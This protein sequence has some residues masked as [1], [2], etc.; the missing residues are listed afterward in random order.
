MSLS[1]GTS[2]GPRPLRSLRRCFATGTPSVGRS[3]VTQHRAGAEH[4]TL[5]GG[6]L[7]T[8]QGQQPGVQAQ[9]SP[10]KAQ[11]AAPVA[12]DHPSPLPTSSPISSSSCSQL[13]SPSLLRSRFTL[14]LP[15]LPQIQLLHPCLPPMLLLLLLLCCVD[16]GEAGAT[17]G[18]V[19]RPAPAVWGTAG[20]AAG[21]PVCMGR[22]QARTSYIGL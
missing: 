8:G 21:G 10:L 15:H 3:H 20:S 1:W 16:A 12:M 13:H 9:I 7:V 17:A 11:L 14:T 2:A 6:L 5:P 18:E 19:A 22:P 4:H